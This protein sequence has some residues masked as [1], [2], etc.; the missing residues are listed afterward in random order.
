MRYNCNSLQAKE[1][2]NNRVL[3]FEIWRKIGASSIFFLPQTDPS[4]FGSSLSCK[5]AKWL[6]WNIHIFSETYFLL[7]DLALLLVIMWS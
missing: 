4:Q 6:K 1:L 5:D 7:N 2:Q 3:K